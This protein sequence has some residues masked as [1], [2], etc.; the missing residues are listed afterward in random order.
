MLA[1]TMVLGLASCNSEEDSQESKEWRSQIQNT[2]WKM[3]EIFMEPDEYS[4]EKE[5]ISASNSDHLMIYELSFDDKGHY[6]SN[7]LHYS[8][9]VGRNIV[10]HSGEYHVQI[11]GSVPDHGVGS[12]DHF[13]RIIF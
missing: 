10:K 7:D 13:S 9:V 8:A 2:R 1:L 4:E 5:W 3:T 11:M 12:T 6:A